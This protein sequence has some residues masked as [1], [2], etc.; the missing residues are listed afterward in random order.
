M[1]EHPHP[2]III[3]NIHEAQIDEKERKPLEYVG[4]EGE[5]CVKEDINI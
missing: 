3:E 1:S 5:G 2:A 4:S